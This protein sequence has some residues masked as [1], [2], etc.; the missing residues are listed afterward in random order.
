MKLG[1]ATLT[2]LAT[3]LLAIL[4]GLSFG[5]LIYTVTSEHTAIHTAQKSQQILILANETERRV[6]DLET[7]ER[8]FL[9]T[10]EQRF[11]EPWNAA[12]AALPGQLTELRGLVADEPEQEDRVDALVEDIDSYVTDHSVPVVDS[13]SAGIGPQDLLG[14][15]S[16]GR[17]RVDAIRAQFDEFTSAQTAIVVSERADED[18]RAKR[19]VTFAVGGL[20]LS[21][22][23]ITGYVFFLR[24]AIVRPLTDAAGLASRVS[25]GDLDVRMPGTGVGEIGD[26]EHSFN[27]MAESL[28]TSRAGLERY[29]TEQTVLRGIATLVAR[30]GKADEVFDA[31]A[32]GMANV[33]DADIATIH[34]VE[35]DHSLTTVGLHGV[36][37]ESG[38]MIG[39]D[40]FQSAGLSD[41]LADSKGSGRF[42]DMDR[43]SGPGGEDVRRLGIRSMVT[44]RISVEGS[45]WGLVAVS[46]RKGPF[47]PDTEERMTGF[48]ELV[49]TAVASAQSRS[50][51]IASRARIVS[52]SDAARRKIERD[53]HDGAQQRLV[54]TALE[55]RHIGSNLPAHMTE[56]RQRLATIGDA[57]EGVLED[58]R[59][60]S[61]G[62]HPAIL[63]QGGLA[64][65]LKALA[66]RS[67]IPAKS[68][69]DI[70]GRL[71]E[72]VE[73]AAYFT[74][75]E[76]LTNAAKHAE[77]TLVEIRARISEGWL[78][79]SVRDDGVGGADEAS[80]SGLVGLH[81]RIS[82]IG[83][84]FDLSSPRGQGT[85][86]TVRLPT[87]SPDLAG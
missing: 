76:A 8:G 2:G 40:L 5:M 86:L 46:S 44:G 48:S 39:K 11:L 43:L 28:A 84:F 9:L 73:V 35:S 24:R 36:D 10:H 41:T 83:G 4:I 64:P 50:E 78:E 52:A 34:R 67:S 27:S 30:G 17:S 74:V 6:V 65:A 62:I 21:V 82:V 85:S 31:V 72:P 20:V 1:L 80:G 15:L 33:F 13:A 66:R 7:G 61:R 53:L 68:D 60:I 26:L 49:A 77:A 32:E 45:L 18:A 19:A 70:E 71:P 75:S 42:D 29:A 57:L 12:R 87:S 3:A 59:E 69:V 14:V 47:P 81:D 54:T 25:M 58:L 16:E 23:L 37:P 79:L 55:L 22:L 51:L 38:Q 63:S 56:T